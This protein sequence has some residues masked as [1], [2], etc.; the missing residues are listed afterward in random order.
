MVNKPTTKIEKLNK[1][2]SAFWQ[3]AS[4]SWYT[5]GITGICLIII[6]IRLATTCV[7]MFGIQIGCQDEPYNY[8]VQPYEHL[9]EHPNDFYNYPPDGTETE[10]P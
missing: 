9:Y 1:I 8:N 4:R 6:V 10:P 5:R 3:W 2:N 7:D